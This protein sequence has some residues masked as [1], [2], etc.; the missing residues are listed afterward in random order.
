MGMVSEGLICLEFTDVSHKEIM[1]LY[2]MSLDETTFTLA[3]SF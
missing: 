2:G 3:S 1:L